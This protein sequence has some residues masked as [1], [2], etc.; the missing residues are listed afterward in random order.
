VSVSDDQK[1]ADF[2][3]KE[4]NQIVRDM[5]GHVGDQLFDVLKRNGL[6]M[7]TEA[8]ATSMMTIAARDVLEQAIDQ[9]SRAAEDDCRAAVVLLFCSILGDETRKAFSDALVVN[10]A[11]KQ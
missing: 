5:A 10:E 2:L 8:G 6:A 9:C 7:M 11:G 3:L 1:L 4:S